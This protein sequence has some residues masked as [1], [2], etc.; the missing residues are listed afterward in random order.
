MLVH[1]GENGG[2]HGKRVII[3]NLVEETVGLS[4]S[5][6]SPTEVVGIHIIIMH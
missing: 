5:A 1:R 3:F 4:T 2:D 6:L